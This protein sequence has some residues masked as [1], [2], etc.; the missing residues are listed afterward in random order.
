MSK[1][2]QRIHT[3]YFVPRSCFTFKHM[4]K[5]K[6]NF[7]MKNSDIFRISAQNIDGLCLSA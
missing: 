5:N 6:I 1:T 3:R 7:M 4:M 2:I